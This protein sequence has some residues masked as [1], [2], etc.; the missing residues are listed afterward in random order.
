MVMDPKSQRKTVRWYFRLVLVED[1]ALFA[2]LVSIP[3]D[4]KNAW[5]LGMSPSRLAI[6]AFVAL[7]TLAALWLVIKDRV[8]QDL[9]A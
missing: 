7:M 3:A 4:P 6:L 5:L 8:H 9:S 1:L 2:A